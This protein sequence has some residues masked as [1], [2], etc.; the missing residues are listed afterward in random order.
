MV[1]TSIQKA[2]VE[3]IIAMNAAVQRIRLFPVTNPS[4]AD[5]IDNAFAAV[6][7]VLAEEPVFTLER[8]RKGYRVLGETLG[9]AEQRKTQVAAFLDLVFGFGIR[10]LALER[11]VTRDAFSRLLELLAEKP[12]VLERQ[13]GLTAAAG[14]RELPHIHLDRP[15]AEQI[16]SDIAGEGMRDR[17][18]GP[19]LQIMDAL[20]GEDSPRITG[21][22]ADAISGKEDRVAAAFLA[23]ELDGPF[24]R[25]LA[26]EMAGRLDEDRLER[27]QSIL[28]EFGSPE[29]LDKL[30]GNLSVSQRGRELLGAVSA[31]ERRHLKQG[32]EALLRGE[33]A[34]LADRQLLEALPGAIDRLVARENDKTGYTI[35]DKLAEILVKEDDPDQRGRL[36]PVMVRVGENL[37]AAD[38]LEAMT[39]FSYR[40][41][42]WVRFDDALTPSMEAVC[43]QL[44][45]LALRLIREDRFDQATHILKVFNA[46]HAGRI[47]KPEPFRAVV[48]RM[49][50]EIAAGDFFDPLMERIYAADEHVRRQAMDRMAQIG[51]GA[52]PL[53]LERLRGS[54]SKM[55]RSRILRV[56]IQMGAAAVPSLKAEI[57]RDVPWYYLRNLVLLFGKI[58]GPE[59]L[60]V[61]QP[62]LTHEDNRVRREVI[63]CLY[64][65]GGKEGERLLISALPRMEDSLKQ[66]IIGNLAALQSR[67]AVSPLVKF[68]ES[69]TLAA[70]KMRNELAIKVCNALGAIGATEAVAPLTEILEHRRRSS[71]ISKSRDDRVRAAVVDA[72]ETIW[73]KAE[74]T[75]D[76]E[77]KG[78]LGKAAEPNR[79]A[80]PD[81]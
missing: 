56:I 34:P 3:A 30:S 48:D 77:K 45:D 80:G 9:D 13:G 1:D 31:S 20:A 5:F 46:I 79:K 64:A 69:E 26:E 16:P 42:G 15:L 44:K 37:M 52:V 11:G 19:F 39:R 24:G 61:I 57:A 21:L 32:I 22:L 25:A 4:T 78:I 70:S 68:L 72:L 60:P 38:R 29:A 8:A 7:K 50:E 63:N 41:A 40:L 62:Y 23:R 33:R 81:A 28:K 59:N 6:E 58:G 73:K 12:D 36:A 53:L 65:I 67:Q 49:L 47:E 2:A 14:E 10:T 75:G 55:E 71:F 66:I 43:V 27:I 18:L 74:D 51:G 17:D 35:L 76:K 54:E